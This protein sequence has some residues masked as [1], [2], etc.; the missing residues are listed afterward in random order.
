MPWG[1]SLL[2]YSIATWFVLWAAFFLQMERESSHLY[3]PGII[4]G[5]AWLILLI[6]VYSAVIAVRCIAQVIWVKISE[7]RNYT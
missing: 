4:S 3:D 7:K 2:I 1:K 5:G 6:L